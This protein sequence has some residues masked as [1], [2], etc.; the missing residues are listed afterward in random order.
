MHRA[1]KNRAVTAALIL[2]LAPLPALAK[3]A[4]RD[5]DLAGSYTLSAETSGTQGT[6]WTTCALEIGA[7]GRV[8]AGTACVQRDQAGTEAAAT[9]NGGAIALARSC[10]VTGSLVI[11]GFES[12]VVK[13]RMSRDKRRVEGQAANPH[14]GSSV[15]FT[16]ARL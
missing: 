10:K 6:F 4:C 9:V 12:V 14:D 15:I 1:P 3:G 8:A 16:A 5:S 13:A 2:S 11:A 7:D